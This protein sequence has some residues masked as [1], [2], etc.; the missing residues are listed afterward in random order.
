MLTE[1]YGKGG[2]VCRAASEGKLRC[3]LIIRPTSEDVIT[4]NL[5]ETF[6]V[7]NPRW[8]LPDVLNLG[9]K[10][11]RFRRQVYR[12]LKIEPWR[13]RPRYPREFLPWDE[14]STQ[15]DLCIQWENPPTTVYVETKYLADLSPRTTNWQAGFPADQLIRNIRVGLLECGW[16]RSRERFNLPPR[17]FVV[18]LLGP[19]KGHPLVERYRDPQTLKAAIPHSDRLMG[20]P[21]APFVGEITFGDVVRVLRRQSRWFTRPERQLV[22]DLVDYLAFKVRQIPTFSGVGQVQLRITGSPTTGGYESCSG[23]QSSRADRGP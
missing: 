19:I 15:I 1:M 11:R 4:A 6:R 22:S 9:L 3:P 16:F 18:L 8:W 10:A 23:P 17:D 21:A 12:G 13:N 14:G 2:K 7:L 20:L 5:C